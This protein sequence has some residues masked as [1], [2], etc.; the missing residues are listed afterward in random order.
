MCV[1]VLAKSDGTTLEEH[2]EDVLFIFRELQCVVPYLEQV[3]QIDDFWKLLFISILFHDFGKIHEEFQKMLKTEIN[4]WEN[5]RHEIYSIPFIDKVELYEDK[6]LLIK[7]VVLSHHKSFK[8]LVEKYLI[9]SDEVNFEYKLIWKAKGLLYHPK[10]FEKNIKKKFNS[11]ILAYFFNKFK[12]YQYKFGYY[13]ELKT[14]QLKE[15]INPIEKYIYPI[16]KKEKNI[17]NK[18]GLILLW[19]AL[20]VCDH[21][22]SS[23]INKLYVLKEEHFHFLSKF[24]TFYKHQTLCFKN[25]NSI[26]IAPTGSGKT[27]AAV[28][29]IKERILENQGRVFYILPYTASINAMHKRL[30]KQMDNAEISE[31]VALQHGNVA[32]YLSEY[33]EKNSDKE[34]NLEKNKQIKKIIEQ[35]RSI[36]APLIICTPFQLLKFFYGVKGFEKGFVFLCGAKIVFDEIHAYDVITFSQIVSMIKILKERFYCNILI[37]TATLPS[38]MRRILEEALGLKYNQIIKAEKRFLRNLKRHRIELVEGDIFSQLNNI[39]EIINKYKKRVIVVCNTVKNAQKFF[40]LV[41]KDKLSRDNIVLLHSRFTKKDRREKEKLIF[42]KDIKLLIGTQAIE[43]SLD[44]D[45][46]AMFTEPAPLDALIQRFGRINRKGKKEICPIYISKIGG[47]NDKYI[48]PEQIT[49]K[50][51]RVLKQV[52]EIDE[53]KLQELLDQVYSNWSQEDKQL[54]ENTSLL[55]RKFFDN[56]EAFEEYEESEEKFYSQFENVSVLPIELFDQYKRFIEVFDFISAE[57]LFVDIPRKMFFKYLNEGKI[58]K[59]DFCYLT[60]IEN[61]KKKKIFLAKMKY[62]S[63][64]G[65]TEE[66]FNSSIAEFI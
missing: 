33:F 60:D 64:V 65:L 17:S 19:G 22:G 47:D 23:K 13:F 35:Y 54:F 62:S 34:Y 41:V 9:F 18:L 51:L 43:V 59:I 8:E 20:K 15:L 21:L 24:R 26:L 4:F 2:I 63:S 53:E 7:L 16:Y 46:D 61:V 49:Y 5:Q 58:E 30:S 44:I 66:I 39:T 56:L 48:Y 37:M 11:K 50:T 10:D 57:S 55:F 1:D 31:I 52:H 27:E 38:F 40:E 42:E 28:G 6:N 12:E 25:K 32:F 29:W 3:S 45:F 14:I 36:L